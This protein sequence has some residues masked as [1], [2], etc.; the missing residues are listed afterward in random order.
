MC[1]SAL[2]NAGAPGKLRSLLKAALWTLVIIAFPVVSGVIAVVN[3]LD[4]PASRLLQAAFMLLSLI[5]LLLYG[6]WKRISKRDLLLQ[7]GSRAGFAAF[8]YGLPLLLVFLPALVTG[9]AFTAPALCLATLFFTLTVGLAEEL[10][11]RGLILHLLQKSFST[12]G[13]VVASSL[14]FGLGHASSALMARSALM[15][16]LTVLSA[17]IFGWLAAEIALL[18][19]HIPVL[20]LFHALFNFID[21]HMTA[22]GDA[23][24]AA[25]FARGAVMLALALWLFLG[26]RRKASRS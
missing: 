9:I 3:H 20:M 13:A 23:L 24:A 15:V 7:G 21:Y 22:Q 8:Y 19:E 6:R 26:R 5:P 25:Y 18:L 2:N 4:G 14:L 1:I 17:L 11:F 16:A 10:Y 12:G